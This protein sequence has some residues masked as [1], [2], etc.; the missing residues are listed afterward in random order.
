METRNVLIVAGWGLGISVLLVLFI[1]ML[2]GIPRYNAY[3]QTQAAEALMEAAIWNRKIMLEDAR[4]EVETAKLKAQAEIERAR[5]VAEATKILGESLRGNEGYLKYLWV[6]A[7]KAGTNQVIYVPTE[8]QVPIVDVRLP[9]A[10][11]P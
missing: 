2:I 1:G 5:G 7:V 3:R 11:V 4:N 9:P 8:A 10:P 6:E